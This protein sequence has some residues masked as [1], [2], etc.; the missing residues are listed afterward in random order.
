[1]E[2]ILTYEEASKVH[3]EIA[4][5]VP[6]LYVP[7]RRIAADRM[8]QE[9]FEEI[10]TSDVSIQLTEMIRVWD[11][12]NVGPFIKAYEACGIEFREDLYEDGRY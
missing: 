6:T 10:G 12:P 3:T 2:M 9:G 4:R 1:M 5:T 8:V 7:L 11:V